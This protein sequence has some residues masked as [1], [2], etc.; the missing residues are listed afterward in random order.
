[1]WPLVRSPLR[2]SRCNQWLPRRHAHPVLHH[3]AALDTP[4]DVR[5]PK[6]PLVERLVVPL[7]LPGQLRTAWLLRRHQDRHL[8]ERAGQAA[9]IRH[10]PT[11]GRE[12]GG[13][14]LR[15]AQLMDTA[16]VGGAQ[17]KDDEHGLDEQDM[18]DGVIACLPALTGLLCNRILGA[19]EPPCG[20]V[21]GTRGE[22][23]AAAGAAPRGASSSSRGATTG[24][25]SAAETPRR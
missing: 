19:D 25:A 22:A 7:L 20:P 13:G 23:G 15:E 10:Q 21:M 11:P 9:Q 24:A 3:A 16:A 18:F 17:Q 4:V 1:M 14:G 12:R 8:R 6:P 2:V 5:D